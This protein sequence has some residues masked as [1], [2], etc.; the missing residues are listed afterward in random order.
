MSDS[1]YFGTTKK[2][3]VHELKEDLN[4]QKEDKKKEVCTHSLGGAA[5]A[6]T[7]L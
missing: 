2:G 3:E 6:Q 1:K 5:G 4:S 7:H